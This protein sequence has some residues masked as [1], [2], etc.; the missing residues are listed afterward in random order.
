MR[1]PRS[2][3][4]AG[5]GGDG[6]SGGAA[7]SHRRRAADAFEGARVLKHFR[8]HGDFVGVARVQEH[9]WGFPFRVK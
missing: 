1:P 3:P 7:P 8:G 5:G 6:A 9:K 4:S 2:A